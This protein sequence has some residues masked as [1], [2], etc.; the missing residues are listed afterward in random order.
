[1]TSPVE[2]ASSL[3]KEGRLAAAIDA[4]TRAVKDSPSDLA[5]RWL[6][7]ELLIVGG[8]LERADKQLDTL[9]SLDARAAVNVIPL[10]HLVRAE[11][12]RREF[13]RSASLPEFLAEGPTKTLRIGSIPHASYFDCSTAS[14]CTRVGSTFGVLFICLSKENIDV[15]K[16]SVDLSVLFRRFRST[17]RTCASRGCGS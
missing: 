13:F 7:A 15:V 16:P 1:M 8:D 9:M 14:F 10:R 3:Y 4:A 11:T 17:L 12:A 5:A 2:Q 6:L